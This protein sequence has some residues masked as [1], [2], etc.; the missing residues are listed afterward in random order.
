MRSK[1]SRIARRYPAIPL[2]GNI[3]LIHRFPFLVVKNDKN[4]LY[5]N[6]PLRVIF[7]S[8]PELTPIV[9]PHRV[10]NIPSIGQLC[11]EKSKYQ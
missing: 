10:Y 5:H 7:D 2:A 4:A 8:D 6:V 11:Y 1:I 9:L 3:P